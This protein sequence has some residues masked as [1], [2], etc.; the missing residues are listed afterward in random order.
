MAA[1]VGIGAA[2]IDRIGRLEG[3]FVPATS[4]PGTVRESVGGCMANVL[5]VACALNACSVGLVS[6][7][8]GDLAGRLVA[9]AMADAGIDDHSAVFVDRATPSYTAILD[10]QGEVIVAL[11]D[12]ALYENGLARHVRR[13]DVRALVGAADRLVVDANL[14][15]TA[16]GTLLDAPGR[17]PA[18]G[19]TVSPAKAGRLR[20]RL[21]GLALVV[22]NR[23]ELAALTGAETRQNGPISLAQMAALHRSGARRAVV[24]DGPRGAVVLEDDRCWRVP[25]TDQARV[26]DVTGAGDALAGAVLAHWPETDLVAAVRIGHA[27]AAVSIGHDGPFAPQLARADLAALAGS[28]PEPER[29]GSV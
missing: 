15:A 10:A 27:A 6:A 3:T 22:M 24:T 11:A 21:S 2:H 18:V 29:L 17:P 9:E 8:G 25:T 13:S 4:Q 16:I 19:L 23:R 26:R 5:R 20:G 12:M 1:L 14:P 28:L 7:R